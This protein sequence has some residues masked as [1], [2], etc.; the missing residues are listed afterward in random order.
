MLKRIIFTSLISV[1]FLGCLNKQTTIVQTKIKYETVYLSANKLNKKDP[2]DLEVYPQNAQSYTKNIKNLT[3]RQKDKLYKEFFELY[4]RPWNVSK[5]TMSKKNAFWGNNYARS[6]MYGENYRR[7]SKEWFER[8][9]KLSNMPKFASVKQRAITVRNSDLKVFPTSKPMFKRFDQAGEGFPFDYNQNSSINLNSPLYISHYSTDNGWAFVE[10]SFA[11]GWI[12][13]QDIATVDADV[14]GKFKSENSYYVAIK[15]NFPLYKS[16]VFKDYVKLGTLFPLRKGKFATVIRDNTGKGYIS[17]VDRNKNIVSFPI[18][19][20]KKNLNM[21][22]NQLIKQPYGWGGLYGNR[23]CSLLTKDLL[24]PFAFPLQ[25][26][27]FGQTRNG[28]Y[29]SLEGK[30]NWQKKHIL[31]TQGIPFLSLVY[32]PGHIAL[33]I[34]TYDGE[35]M[36]FHS[37]WG[38]KTI[39]NGVE[40]RHIVGKSVIS[41]LEL[42]KELE[43]YNPKKSIIYKVKGLVL[44]TK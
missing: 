21:V 22:I 8:I 43:D 2:K 30:S 29:I 10:S 12:S 37:T 1:L 40:G 44:L 16:Y 18:K 25:R 28:K 7:I 6:K 4:F 33:Y 31:K 3:K 27:S 35:P 42:G 11:S 9:I 15:D 34:G 19:F 5:M 24:T 26:N 38:V 17:R 32:I 36:I 13:V 20:N 14:I 23:D 39:K 41:S